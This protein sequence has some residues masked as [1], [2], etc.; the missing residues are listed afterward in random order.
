MLRTARDRRTNGCRITPN[1]MESAAPCGVLPSPGG[2][3]L[4]N[5]AELARQFAGRGAAR[6]HANFQAAM[7]WVSPATSLQS[8]CVS[9]PPYGRT[10]PVA[11]IWPMAP[12][13]EKFSTPTDGSSGSARARALGGLAA[14]AAQEDVTAGHECAMRALDAAE[15]AGDLSAT[16][17]ARFELKSLARQGRASGVARLSGAGKAQRRRV[18]TRSGMPP[19]WNTLG[20]R[21]N[22]KEMRGWTQATRNER[23]PTS[24]ARH[25]WGLA[26]I[27]RARSR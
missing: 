7:Q 15:H 5:S 25:T 13:P 27:A 10:G 19:A 8:G 23:R 22:M 26:G 16:A 2:T 17:L 11:A 24:R 9:A 20:S 3:V 14:P 6:E 4:C 18:T 1:W 21:L 12:N